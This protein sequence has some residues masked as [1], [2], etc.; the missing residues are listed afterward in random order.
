MTDPQYALSIRQPWA[1]A[2]L[3]AG[4]DIE[5][6]SWPAPRWMIGQRFWVHV[7]KWWR[8][9]DVQEDAEDAID[10]ARIRGVEPPRVT[11]R[12]L[13]EQT[14][15]II[16][17]ARLVGCVTRSTSPWFV[18]PVGFVLAD[19]EPCE[20]RPCKGKLGFWRVEMQA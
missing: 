20:F 2:I 16:G 10:L 6:R 9:E 1:W 18:G 13:R 8:P 12:M 7:S 4:K 14:G 15:G 11:L 3:H 19:R 17:S 5:N